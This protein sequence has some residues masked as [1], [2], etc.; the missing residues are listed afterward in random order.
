MQIEFDPKKS[1]KNEKERA[2]P[3][4]LVRGLEWASP[5]MSDATTARS[6]FWLSYQRIDA[7]ISSVFVA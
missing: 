6:D 1:A 2:L 7:C 4:E 5:V 3:F